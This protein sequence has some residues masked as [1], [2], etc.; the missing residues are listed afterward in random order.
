MTILY[1]VRHAEPDYTNHNDME[2]PLTDKGRADSKRVTKFLQN[3][4]IDAVLSSPYRRAVDTVRDLAN[5]INQ[6]IIIIDD[7]R[8]RRVDNCWIDDFNQFTKLQ[9][10]DFN[11]KLSDGECLQEVQYRNIKALKHVL[12]MYSDKNIVIG[13][14]GTAL[15]TIINYYNPLFGYE[16]FQRIRS[17]MPWIVTFNFFEE[18]IVE[19]NEIDLFDSNRLDGIL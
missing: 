16:E 4:N 3:K 5:N 7:F 1:F 18:K 13:S 9:W 19:I 14:H 2:R 15:S 10:S 11:F 8:E 12:Q 6:E 17:K